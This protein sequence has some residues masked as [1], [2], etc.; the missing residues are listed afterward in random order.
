M[1]N[2]HTA[3]GVLRIAALAG[4]VAFIVERIDKGVA[5]WRVI[6]EVKY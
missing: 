3:A 4:E 2:S 5:C 1:E 6:E